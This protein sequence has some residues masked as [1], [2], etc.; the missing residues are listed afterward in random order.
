M[1]NFDKY[2]SF[3]LTFPFIGNKIY[4]S[5]SKEKAINKCYREY[6]LLQQNITN[7]IFGVT[8]LD[9]K[10]EYRFEINKTNLNN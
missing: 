4:R 7:N 1:H 5:K 3:Q 2:Y 10:I 8:D 6:K 9:R